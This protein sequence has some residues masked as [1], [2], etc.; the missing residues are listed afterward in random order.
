MELNYEHHVIRSFLNSLFF[1]QVHFVQEIL[2][3]IHVFSGFDILS[4]QILLI[5]YGEVTKTPVGIW[6]LSTNRE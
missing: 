6:P 3:V 4:F 5:M 1:I 2:S